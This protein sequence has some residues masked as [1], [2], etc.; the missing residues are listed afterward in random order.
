[1]VATPSLSVVDYVILSVHFAACLFVGFFFARG[2]NTNA[3]YFLGGRQVQGWAIAISLISGISSGISYLGIPAYTFVDGIGFLFSAASYIVACSVAAWIVVPFFHSLG[4]YT[5]YQYLELRFN[6]VV[7]TIAACIFITRVVL[8]LAIVLTAPAI[9]LDTLT[10]L[11][12]WAAILVSGVLATAYTVK[13]GIMAVVW[14]DFL[15]SVVMIGFAIVAVVMATA[16]IDGGF[17]GVSHALH[18]ASRLVNIEFLRPHFLEESGTQNESLWSMVIGL[19]FL[20]LGQLA[21]DQIAVQRYLT[22]SSVA[23]CRRSVYLN[24]LVQGIFTLLLCYLGMALF[25]FYYQSNVDPLASGAISN[26]DAI[27]PYF[28]LTK[29]PEGLAGLLIAAILGS[30]MSVFAGGINAAATSLYVDILQNVWRVNP[31]KSLF[32]TRVASIALSIVSI[33]I[34]FAAAQKTGLVQM[35]IIVTAVSSPLLGVFLLGILVE[36]S[37]TPGAIIGLI[38]GL[39][40]VVWVAVGSLVCGSECDGAASPGRLSN[41]WLA[42]AGCLTTVIMGGLASLFFPELPPEFL[43]GLT[44]RTRAHAQIHAYRIRMSERATDSGEEEVQALIQ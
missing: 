4:L 3:K 31:A 24:G 6:K 43:V 10:S 22:A 2:Q 13:G 41:F 35:G 17:S 15:Q 7:R 11:P 19:G 44:Y 33:S 23:A 1:M 29:L 16:R 8:Y 34:A 21:T 38:S 28:A 5:A 39:V 30:S 26:K 40:A 27:L 20:S 25:A 12:T 14:T 37:N 42:T 9:V 36:R 32:Y 18:N